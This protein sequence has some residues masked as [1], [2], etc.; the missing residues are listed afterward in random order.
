MPWMISLTVSA[1]LAGARAD[2]A[3]AAWC[4]MIRMR[5]S[6]Y[7]RMCSSASSKRNWDFTSATEVLFTQPPAGQQRK[8]GC[9]YY[10]RT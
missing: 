6:G 8:L 1:S 3:P 10:V 7:R 5:A 4:Q 2:G 9:V